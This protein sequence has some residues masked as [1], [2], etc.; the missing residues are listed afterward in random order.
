MISGSN[1][2]VPGISAPTA[3]TAGTRTLYACR[4]VQ[5]YRD[6]FRLKV[7]GPALLGDFDRQNAHL[8][9]LLLDVLAR[10]CAASPA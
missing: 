10:S 6:E 3:R 7:Y 5:C 2:F 9:M 8:M 1:A 4:W